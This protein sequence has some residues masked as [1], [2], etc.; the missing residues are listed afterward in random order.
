[1]KVSKHQGQRFLGTS[2]RW[3]ARMLV[4]AAALLSS[5]ET[6][7]AQESV[8]AHAREHS[9][10]RR[11]RAEL[12]PMT[13]DRPSDTPFIRAYYADVSRGVPGVR[14]DTGL[15]AAAGVKA[16]VH[17][18]RPVEG[19]DLRGTVFVVH[20]YLAH[21]L[22]HAALIRSL[23]QER[24]V[25]VAPELPGHALSG[26]ARGAIRDFSQYG[27]FLRDVVRSA[28]SH[29]PRPW[30]AVGHSTGAT[31]VYEYVR[32]FDDP[33]EAVVFVA[34]LVRSRFYGLSRVGDFSCGRF[35][36]RLPPGTRTRW[37]W[38]ECP[39]RGSTNRWNGTGE[40][41]TLNG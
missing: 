8:Q 35:S 22:Q 23:L 32:R 27:V 9:E 16:A 6:P 1:M 12:A 4:I 41:A 31:T 26:G 11:M 17:V 37:A 34:P 13:W 38:S 20:G 10:F 25:V 18:W 39:S 5:C 21:P 29:V 7:V 30:H 24:F 28:S 40:R 33:F 15:V 19:T 14:H 2:S 36:T 3:A